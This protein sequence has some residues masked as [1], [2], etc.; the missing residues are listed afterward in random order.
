MGIVQTMF[1]KKRGYK[2][3]L[4]YDPHN[5]KIGPDGF[6]I[7]YKIQQ[8]LLHHQART[9]AAEPQSTEHLQYSPQARS[10]GSV[11]YQ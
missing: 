6:S 11:V 4:I 1:P 7:E 10:S 3:F 5:Y 2:P 9:R 8:A